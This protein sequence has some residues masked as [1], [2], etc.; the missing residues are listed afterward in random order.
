MNSRLIRFPQFLQGARYLLIA[1]FCAGL[2]NAIM[3][4]LDLFGMHYGVSLVISAGVLMP[5]GF[6]L[7]SAYTFAAP[8]TMQSFWRYASVM[9]VNTPISFILLWLLYDLVGLPMIVAAPVATV[10]LLI[11]NFL[12]SGW[13]IRPV[14][15]GRAA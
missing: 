9:I 7:Q 1:G 15:E 2:H 14:P 12:A 13:A 4:V 8:R 10:L 6:F 5:T 11:W 3:I